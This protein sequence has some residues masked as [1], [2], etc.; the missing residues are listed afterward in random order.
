MPFPRSTLAAQVALGRAGRLAP[1]SNFAPTDGVAAFVLGSD[2]PG[3]FIDA[4]AGNAIEVSNIG[5]FYASGANTFVRFKV[6]VRPGASAMPVG[7]YWRL[8]AFLKN[9]PDGGSPTNPRVE[10]DIK[11]SN[12]R[13][14]THL[15]FAI[16][17]AGQYS[18]ASQQLNLRLELVAGDTTAH[19]VELPGVYLDSVI[20]DTSA[21]RP[22]IINRMPDPNDAGVPIDSDIYLEITDPNAAHDTTNGSLDNISI[23]VNGVL[24][25]LLGVGTQNFQPGFDGPDSFAILH[26][27]VWDDH[28]TAIIRI[29]PTTNFTATSTVNV[30]VLALARL[31]G[32]SE[33]PHEF[34]YAF[35]TEDLTA[36][37]LASAT[38]LDLKTVRVVASE[39]LVAVDP[40]G[41]N[42]A[43]NPANWA[44]FVASTSL[45]D[46]LPAVT[47]SVV[48]VAKVAEG[49]YDLTTETEL[50]RGATY[51]VE[52]GPIEDTSGNPMVVPNNRAFFVGFECVG[53][54]G[55][56][57]QLIDMLP[58]VNVNE[59]DTDDLKKFVGCYQE[60]TDLLLCDVDH[61]TDIL[62]PDIA[63]ERF[64]DVML[65]DLGNPFTFDLSDVDKR[66]LIRVL[67]PIYQQKGT[68]PGII[69][70]VRFFIGI[71][72]SIYVPSF[73]SVWT[74]GV[75]ELGS[76]TWL[77]SS[78][79]RDRLSFYIVSPISL[80]QTQRDQI[81][82]IVNYMKD[83]RTHFLGIQE[84]TL[85][86][87]PDHWELGLSEL[88]TETI[89]H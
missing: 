25:L 62:D 20:C 16:P 82:S 80:T 59:D 66:R 73:D 89:L 85:P 78:S 54:A 18:G 88:G 19:T 10:F 47:S 53:A 69:N 55:R 21:D 87:V 28:R 8:V 57:F 70:A 2:V 61:W 79:L 27:S 13:E 86:T 12:N 34:N 15:D 71:E 6:H 76:G 48:L 17:M 7:V 43:L 24:A 72:V 35:N 68:D 83:A 9:N 30:R 36:P 31:T 63:P 41:A 56:S 1:P 50:T 33:S 3:V 32:V 4:E 23:Y 75:S 81:T 14:A 52:G 5:D 64:V 26:S 74:L 40:T 44:I 45:A 60:T 39:P 65:R 42:D 29:D 77:G 46:G 51:R 49:V 67:V 38:A 84:P 58:D 37:T 22:T 11:D